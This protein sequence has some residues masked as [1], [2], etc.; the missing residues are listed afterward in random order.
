V[1]I[2]LFLLA[3]VSIAVVAAAVACGALTGDTNQGGGGAVATPIGTAAAAAPGQIAGATPEAPVQ[4]APNAPPTVL[5]DRGDCD[6]IR[7]TDYHS[8]T[9]REWFLEYCLTPVPTVPVVPEP[10][11]PA[12]PGPE[13]VGERWILVDLA[14]QTTT[15]MIGDQ[16]LYT[17]LVTTGTDGWETPVGTW[18]INYRVENETM[19][20]ESIGA[21]EYYVLE[22]VLYTQYFT[23][24]G[25]ALHLNYWRSDN[26]FGNIPSSHGCVG[27][28][29][30]DAEFFWN[31][32]SHGT[33]VT[34]Q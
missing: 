29:L 17:A 28:R 12:I 7:G 11:P 32:A 5:P 21:E 27:M 24:E 10:D 34:I 26:Y 22:D 18:H 31:F 25:H 23:T 19:T 6:E 9:E 30:A 14:S 13:I 1:S 3:F 33:R 2:K 15:A 16:A 8:E 20:S 4:S